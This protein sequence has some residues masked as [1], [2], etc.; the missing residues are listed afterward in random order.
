MRRI[1]AEHCGAPTRSIRLRM[2]ECF[3]GGEAIFLLLKEE[4]ET[5]LW[6]IRGAPIGPQIQPSSK[7]RSSHPLSVVSP[8]T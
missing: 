1:A 3:I 4:P 8:R 6:R 5:G 7:A 2:Y